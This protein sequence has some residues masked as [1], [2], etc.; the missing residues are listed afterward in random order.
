MCSHCGWDEEPEEV[1]A[2]IQDGAEAARN[3]RWL[4]DNP[5]ELL[6]EKEAA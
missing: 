5:G 6:P 4:L 3:I 1:D 2:E